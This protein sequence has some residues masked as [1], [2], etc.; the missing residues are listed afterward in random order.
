MLREGYWN[1]SR[2]EEQNN[3]IDRC[4]ELW[5]EMDAV[6]CERDNILRRYSALLEKKMT[7]K[8]CKRNHSNE[9]KTMRDTESQMQR[10]PVHEDLTI[11]TIESIKDPGASILLF[12]VKK[13]LLMRHM[14]RARLFKDKRTA[15]GTNFLSVATKIRFR[16]TFRCTPRISLLPPP[17]LDGLL[18]DKLWLRMM[19]ARFLARVAD[20]RGSLGKMFRVEFR[21]RGV[22]FKQR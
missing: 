20:V 18:N 16:S 15:S 8:V 6:D 19:Y 11:F 3:A 22:N 9:S 12:S 13:L 14:Y 7:R 2:G 21:T 4:R 1:Q 10:A 5:N 17:P